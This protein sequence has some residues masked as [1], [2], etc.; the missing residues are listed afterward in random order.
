MQFRFVRYLGRRRVL[1]FIP[2]L[3]LDLTPPP[4][5]ETPE[6]AEARE[7]ASELIGHPLNK[8]IM[9][10]LQQAVEVHPCKPGAL[11]RRLRDFKSRG[12]TFGSVPLLAQYLSSWYWL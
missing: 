6:Q 8:P 11:L 3:S 2:D 5:P 10:S 7:M 12:W 9:A 1:K 4:V